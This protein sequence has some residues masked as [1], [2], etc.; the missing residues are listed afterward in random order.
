M[1]RSRERG[2]KGT[3]TEGQERRAGPFAG[4]VDFA[5]PEESVRM[6]KVLRFAVLAV[7]FAVL[8]RVYAADISGTWK[9]T[10]EFDNSPVP[11]TFHLTE[12]GDGVTGTVEGLP[13]TPAEIHDGKIDGDTV[14]FW[15]NTDYQ[16][17]AYK[18]VY[19]GKIAEGEIDFSFGTEDGSWGS[20]VVAKN[21]GPDAA[22]AMP[23]LSGN[24]KGSF[25]Y[26][27][28]AVALTF[29]FT[30]TGDAVTGTI[31]GLPTTP[32]EI[33]DGKIDGDTVNFWIDTDYQGTTYKLVYKGKISADGIKFTLGT[34]DGSWG[35]ELVA[36]KA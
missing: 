7:L 15:V 8:P 32:T 29:H 31:D 10:F 24:W 26:N 6:G 14:S 21:A 27:G 19:K 13:T 2:N 34:E 4:V 9:G 12:S 3:R 20:T 16:G 17:T 5:L 11:L 30:V 23:D 25:D 22:P 18:L 33:H 28:S 36:T 35:T 1:H